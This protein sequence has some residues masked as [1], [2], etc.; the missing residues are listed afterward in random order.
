[1][2]LRN[3][4]I[5]SK[6]I[7]GFGIIISMTIIIAI[8]GNIGI[9]Q[10]HYQSTVLSGLGNLTNEYNLSRLYIRSF[11]HT[12][13]SMFLNRMDESLS[14]VFNGIAEMR[15]K[16]STINEGVILDSL[17]S[18]L[19]LY[20]T[21]SLGS[22]ANITDLGI[23]S[24]FEE[25]LGQEIVNRLSSAGE[26]RRLQILNDF[27]EARLNASYYISTYNEDKLLRAF[28]SIDN[29]L[30]KLNDQFFIYAELIAQYRELLVQLENIG[31]NQAEYDASIPPLGQ[32]VTSLFNQLMGY[33]NAEANAARATSNL[34]VVGF[35]VFAFILA[36]LISF[37]ITKY[38]TS[39]LLR[40]VDVAQ[41][42]ANGN[43]MANLSKKDLLLKDEI[44]LLMRAINDMGNNLKRVV[45]L[46]HKSAISL[47]STSTE[48]NTFAIN[49]SEGANSQAAASEELS[50]SMEESI[51]SMQQNVD[52]AS[53]VDSIAKES[54]EYL[55]LISSKSDE[56]LHSAELITQKIS[57]INDIAFQTNILALNAAVEAAR[58]G[59]AGKG[60]SVVAS[61]VRKLAE[62]SKLAAIDIIA[63]S[64][65]SHKNTDEMAGQLSYII[66]KLDKSLHL[67]QEITSSSKE[68][69]I[70]SQ[71][72]N[73][74]IESLNQITQ[75]N[76]SSFE[77]ISKKSTEL[78]ASAE[79][80]FKS[81]AYFKMS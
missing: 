38:I 45:E 27:Y 15:E 29:I 22:V 47:T 56:S 21:E 62:K 65:K 10:V 16:A 54:G 46:I 2:N 68:Q 66:P 32:Q 35:T 73:S 64:Q 25:Q 58:A 30:A 42:Y 71:Q 37:V 26:L 76:V 3:L 44:G 17:Y 50:A 5:S 52:N 36:L 55:K 20:H 39:R 43:L 48:L 13:D 23:T 11:A 60:F 8:V 4:R 78:N 80:L 70:G 57:V 69:L 28:Q 14:H 53:G 40:I 24:S 72:I 67:I 79:E 81:I 77:Q 59:S 34:L 61:E 74:S 63:M 19:S 6:L 49:L 75:Q 9:K 12:R 51:A 7:T 31:M 18:A 1:M 33:A 41:N